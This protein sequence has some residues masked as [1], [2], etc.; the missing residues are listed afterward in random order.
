M[1]REWDGGITG[2]NFGNGMSQ[3]DKYFLTFD[4]P[5]PNQASP[6]L[7]LKASFSLLIDDVL[8][9]YLSFFMV[10]S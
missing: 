8:L 7:F 10:R 2:Y 6:V 4:R 3:F 1:Q 9:L 5:C